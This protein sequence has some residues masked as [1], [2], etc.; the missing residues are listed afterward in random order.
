LTKTNYRIKYRDTIGFNADLGGRGFHL[1]TDM[2]VRDDGVIFVVSRSSFVQLNIV[3][4]QKVTLDHGYHGQIGSYGQDAG[5]MTGPSALAVDS[6]YNLYLADEFLQRITIFDREGDVLDT[7]GTVGDGD[8]EF[9]APSGL[10]FD[11]EDVLYLVDHRNHRIQKLTADGGFI[12]K[13]GAY[14]NGEGEFNLPWGIALDLE[15]NVCVADWRND[16]IQRFNRDGEF[17]AQHGGSGDGEGEFHRPSRLAFDSSGNMYVADWGNQRV[18]IFDSEGRFMEI[19][20]GQATL[21]K[22]AQE[23]FDA[24][25]DEMR[26]RSTFQEVFKVDTDDKHEI[27]ARIEPYFWDPVSVVVDN[28]DQLYV[29]ETNRHRFQIYER[30]S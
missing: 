9:D 27:A 17:L 14:G 10:V 2:T 3:G 18:Q 8:G 16:R 1:P 29:L 23:Y 5:Q 30:V 19:L 15:G 12:D 26:A 28:D 6:N 22:W 20:Q 13:W 25:Q 21:S 4:I 7:W 11:G 24:Q